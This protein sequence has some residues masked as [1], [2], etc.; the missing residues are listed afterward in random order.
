[1]CMYECFVNIIP[2]KIL[3]SRGYHHQVESPDHRNTYTH[4]GCIKPIGR[5]SL[6]SLVMFTLIVTSELN[7]RQLLSEATTVSCKERLKYIKTCP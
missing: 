1:M 5:C 6:P 4:T 2:L 3:C 7:G